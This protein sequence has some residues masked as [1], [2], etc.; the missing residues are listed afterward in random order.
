[1]L[2]NCHLDA[3]KEAP[4]TKRHNFALDKLQIVKP[5]YV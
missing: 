2:I 3:A 1:M 5:H 4:N